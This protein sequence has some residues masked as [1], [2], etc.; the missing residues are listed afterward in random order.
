[1]RRKEKGGNKR[2]EKKT[3]TGRGGLPIQLVA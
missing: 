1:M 2:E 3:A